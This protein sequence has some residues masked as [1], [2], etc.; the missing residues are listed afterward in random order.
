MPR[1]IRIKV[2]ST[3]R[4]SGRN[5]VVRTTSTVNGKTKTNTTTLRP[6]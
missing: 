5:I 1:P 4:R 6:K 2:S 3:A